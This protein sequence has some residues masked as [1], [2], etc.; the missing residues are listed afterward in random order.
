MFR[1]CVPYACVFLCVPVS[2]CVKPHFTCVPV[3]ITMPLHVWA[4]GGMG[5]WNAAECVECV[6]SMCACALYCMAS[7]WA[8]RI[9]QRVHHIENQHTVGS[10][11]HTNGFHHGA[12]SLSHSICLPFWGKGHTLSRITFDSTS[13]F[14]LISTCV[15]FPSVAGAFFFSFY[16]VLPQH[17]TLHQSSEAVFFCSTESHHCIGVATNHLAQK[18][19]SFRCKA[20]WKIVNLTRKLSNNPLPFT[21]CVNHFFD[22]LTASHFLSFSCLCPYFTYPCLPLPSA[23]V[24]LPSN[25]PFL[26]LICPAVILLTYH[27]RLLYLL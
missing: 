4:C 7:V 26:P 21:F 3:P 20:L 13:V 19:R 17:F 18:L 14:F 22:V 23:I 12:F 11:A 16:P 10:Q 5:V 25:F 8:V 6:S 9:T 1:A 2:T 24:F 15:F 27:T